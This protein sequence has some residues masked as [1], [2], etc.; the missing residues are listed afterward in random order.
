MER[1]SHSEVKVEQ[2][3][4]HTDVGTNSTDLKLVSLWVSLLVVEMVVM[5]VVI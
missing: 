3:N 1:I 4:C 5:M 2:N